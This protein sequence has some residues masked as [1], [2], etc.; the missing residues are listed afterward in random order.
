MKTSFKHLL[1]CGIIF[2][3]I[4]ASGAPGAAQGTPVRVG[5]VQS[6]SYD[7]SRK[8]IAKISAVNDVSMVARVSGVILDQKFASGDIV[9]KGQLLI[10]L[11]DTTYLAA[12]NSAK[13]K[14]AQ[15]EAE[16]EFAKRNLSRQQTL[17]KN[18]ATAESTYDEA[19]RSEATAKAAVDAAKAALLDAENN[20]SYTKI[21]SPID[22]KTNRATY[23]PGNYV[24][25]GSGAL[26][27]IVSMNEMYVNFW[28]SMSDYLNM[29]GGSYE[30]L[31][32]EAVCQVILA[33]GKVFPGK[34]EIVFIDNRVD[35]DTDTIRIRL[36][37]KNDNFVLIPDSLVSVRISKKDHNR[38]AVPVSAVMNNG[39]VTFVYVLDSK[40][41]PQVR[42]VELGAVQGKNQIILKGLKA[43]ERVVFDGTHKVFPN[44]PV[45]PVP[46]AKMETK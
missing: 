23:S 15:C 43:G 7:V 40:N 46:A 2:A 16:Y 20:L 17:W 33:D 29:F 19:V 10:V 14:L 18:K 36:L 42:P 28:I 25:P 30:N 9:K 13:A 12:R 5:E 21:I 44:R 4:A 35:K 34:S 37:V 26:V 38:T 8:Y 31:R 24:T 39:Y 22:G 6:I 3:G 32:K 27:N 45:T 11:E 41:I 1:L